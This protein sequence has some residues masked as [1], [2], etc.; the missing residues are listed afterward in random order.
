MISF[1]FLDE[2]LGRGGGRWGE[3]TAAR[4]PP[5]RE[6]VEAGGLRVRVSGVRVRGSGSMSDGPRKGRS[7]RRTTGG[8]G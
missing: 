2:M 3:Q 5:A 4:S 8:G 1:F 7:G 6:V